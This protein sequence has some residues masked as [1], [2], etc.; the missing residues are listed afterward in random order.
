MTILRRCP[1]SAPRS[2][3]LQ[4]RSRD[5]IARRSRYDPAVQTA[6]FRDQDCDGIRAWPKTLD[7]KYC[8][9]HYDFRG[10]PKY[11]NIKIEVFW[12]LQFYFGKIREIDQEIF[13]QFNRKKLQTFNF[14][15]T[16]EKIRKTA[17]IL[18]PPPLK[19]WDRSGAKAC[20]S[21][22]SRQELSNEYLLAKF[23]FDP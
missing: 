11:Q 5:A 14:L 16:S 20:K 23:G 7:S 17:N 4:R 13:V 9:F 18:T 15:K 21:C 10:G 8:N 6:E 22:R 2:R 3:D 1:P 19:I 12:F